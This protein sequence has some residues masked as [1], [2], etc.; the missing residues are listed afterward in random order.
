VIYAA[1]AGTGLVLGGYAG[2]AVVPVSAALFAVPVRGWRQWR[3]RVLAGA[4]ATAAAVG[5]IGEHALV[6]GESGTLVSASAN[7]VPEVICLIVVGGLAAM[8]FPGLAPT[9]SNREP[10]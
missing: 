2:A 8:L 4:L 5:A 3:P 1:L 6:S 10:K 9:Q 7:A